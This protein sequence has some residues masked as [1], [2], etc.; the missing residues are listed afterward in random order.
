VAFCQWLS[1]RDSAKY[2]LPTEAEWEHACRAGTASLYCN[3]SAELTLPKVANL[4]D[5]SAQLVYSKEWNDGYSRTAPV[6]KFEPNA[7]GLHD[8]HGNV[9]EWCASAFVK[10][11]TLQPIDALLRTTRGGSW[12]SLPAMVRSSLRLPRPA[13]WCCDATGFRVVLVPQPHANSRRGA[14]F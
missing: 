6:G 5:A 1:K 14:A 3:G 4:A 10:Y 11:G 7:F 12:E 2:R 9:Y 8:M 13:S